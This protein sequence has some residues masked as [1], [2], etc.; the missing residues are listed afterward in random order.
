V[1][2]DHIAQRGSLVAPDR[3]RFDFVHPKP[4]THDEL[5]RIE[6]IANDVVL[7]NDEVTTRLMAVDDAREAGARALFGE[8]YGDEVRVV[9]MGKSARDHGSNALGWSVELCGGTHVRRMRRYRLIS[10][11]TGQPRSGDI[12]GCE[13]L[14]APPHNSTDQPSALLPWS[15][16]LLP[17]ETTRTSSPYFFAEQRAGAGFAGVVHRHQPRG[18]LVILQHHVVGD[19]LDARQLIVRDRLG[20]HEVE[21]QP[22]RRHQRAALRDMVAEHLPQGFM[23]QI[24]SRN[25][26][27]GSTCVW[28]DRLRGNSAV[29]A[30]SV[31][32]STVPRCT[33]RSPPSSGIGDA[34]S[35]ALAG[36]QAGIADLAAGF[37]VKRRLV[38]NDGATRAGLERLST[39]LPS[40]TSA[41][42]TPSAVSVS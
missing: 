37:R 8:K 11:S 29:P 9:S 16:A 23:Q 18:N 13:A 14:R 30:L 2:G 6:D 21:A 27:P 7:E 20:M 1:L 28:R 15:R 32:C 12:A 41:A 22:V 10:R 40:F 39:S 42:T 38:Q 24:A 35:H 36:H 3:L 5:A 31:P 19:I 33:T 26:W 34:E 25:D 17:I 4:I